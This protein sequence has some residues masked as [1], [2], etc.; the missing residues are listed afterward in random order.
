MT[1][2]DDFR[3]KSPMGKVPLLE[4]DDGRTLPESNAI[5]VY[6]GE[7][8]RF[9]PA[10]RF[11]RAKVFQWMF[12][13]QNFHEVSVAVR[14][15]V[16]TYE[17]RAHL[18]TPEVLGPLLES[19]NRALGA[20]QT[21]LERT[22][23]LVGDAITIADICLYAYTHSAGEQ[24]GYDMTRFPAVETWLSRVASDQGHVPIEWLPS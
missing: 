9:V 6:L 7:G 19:G 3:A 1:A 8:T 13:E 18:R 14:A 10:D 22:P 5:L 15:A 2:T 17:D 24:G 11:D 21:R 4:F 16:L 23:F 20:M 12:F